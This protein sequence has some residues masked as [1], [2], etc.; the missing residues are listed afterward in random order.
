L[1]HRRCCGYFKGQRC[2]L[3]RLGHP[4][5]TYIFGPPD[6]LVGGLIS[7]HGFSLCNSFNSLINEL[8]GRNATI[9]G[10]MVGSKCDL[11]MH[12]RNEGYPFPYKSGAPKPR[13]WTIS[14]LKGNYNCPYL[15]NET[16]YTVAYISGQGR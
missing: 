16:R 14:Q 3:V 2:Q 9:S 13:F 12:A 8:A 10:H 1:L 15:R 11:K 6:I 7:Y 4:G 5:L